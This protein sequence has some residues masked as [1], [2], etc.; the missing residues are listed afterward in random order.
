MKRL[1]TIV[2]WIVE[3]AIVAGL[4]WK[5]SQLYDLSVPILLV[6]LSPFLALAHWINLRKKHL[7]KR[8]MLKLFFLTEPCV[9]LSFSLLLN[10]VRDLTTVARLRV[11][12]SKEMWAESLEKGGPQ[13]N[14]HQWFK[15]RV[16]RM[17]S[18][19]LLYAMLLASTCI[20]YGN[21]YSLARLEDSE[22]PP[23][24]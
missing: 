11:G 2:S 19:G 1:C 16:E 6:L 21:R 13:E 12:A 20:L 15:D 22:G 9:I 4:V 8:V 23:I 17:K 7:E 10:E 24:S 14:F 5:L 3:L 18:D